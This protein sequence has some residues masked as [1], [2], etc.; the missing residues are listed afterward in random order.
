MVNK[1][2]S[3]DEWAAADA[4]SE[5]SQPSRWMRWRLWLSNET[6]LHAFLWVVYFMAILY[7][8]DL[9]SERTGEPAVLRLEDFVFTIN[10]FLVVIAIN[11]WLLPRYLYRK[12]YLLFLGLST[13]LLAVA[14]LVEE[15]VMEGI[16]YANTRR[17]TYFT[18]FFRTLMD[19]GPTILFFVGF[20][21]AW[22]NLKKQSDLEV[23]EREKTESQL[24]FLKAQL[25]PHFLFNNLNNVYAYAQ[26]R[27]P[28]T[29]EIILQ[30]SGLMRYMLY[31]SRDN[32]VPL[33]KELK[34]LSDF[35]RLQE[36]Q[37]E[38]RGHVDYVVEGRV[39]AQQI[40]PFILIA[41]VENC[42]KHSLSSQAQNISIQIMAHVIENRLLFHCANTY[43][44]TVSRA[45]GYL[46]RGIGLDNVRKRLQLLYPG[47]HRLD[48]YT[49][50][51]T[52]F[53]DLELDLANHAL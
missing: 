44:K 10:Y 34:Y 31:E 36:L 50:E 14:I 2:Q 35:I 5:V 3:I 22:D 46:G 51:G 26:E 21:L 49:R 37:M 18:G 52:Y 6:V 20:K 41:F 27:S 11:Y 39:Q 42:F 28:K 4:P 47:S 7:E 45:D 15:Y 53:V 23:A 30:L 25:N 9:V 17:A 13:L 16:F 1:L 33:S 38:G 43:A 32:F 24:Q 29:P 48:I 19:I 12:R 40:A 8:R